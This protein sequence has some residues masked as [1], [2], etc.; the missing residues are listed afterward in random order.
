MFFKFLRF[1]RGIYLFLILFVD[2][3]SFPRPGTLKNLTALKT[4]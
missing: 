4:P 1:L 3:Y 2:F